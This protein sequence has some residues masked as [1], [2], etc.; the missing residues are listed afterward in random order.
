MP[1]WNG[2][3]PEEGHWMADEGDREHT[4]KPPHQDDGSNDVQDRVESLGRKD[5]AI[6]EEH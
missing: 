2:L 6:Q 3:I 5:A 1:T 4:G